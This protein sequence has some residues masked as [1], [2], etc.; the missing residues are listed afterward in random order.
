MEEIEQNIPT[1]KTDHLYRNEEEM[2]EN[3]D[4]LFFLLLSLLLGCLLRELNKKTKI[5]YSPAVL[6]VGLL[7]GLFAAH[8]SD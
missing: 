4:V 1:T 5:P 6:F 8:S 2:E 7:L 3:A